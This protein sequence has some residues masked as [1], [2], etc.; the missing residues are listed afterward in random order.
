MISEKHILH[1]KCSAELALACDITANSITVVCYDLALERRYSRSVV[2]GSMPPIIRK[3]YIVFSTMRTSAG[4]NPPFVIVSQSSMA[5]PICAA[6][7][8]LSH[9]ARS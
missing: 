5:S 6:S 4:G 9:T 2:F 1:E 8:A 7:L 3:S